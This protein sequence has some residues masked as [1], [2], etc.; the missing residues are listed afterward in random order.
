MIRTLLFIF[1]TLVLVSGT[2]AQTI[3]SSGGGTGAWNDPLS[4]SP[5][6]VPTVA[7]SSSVLIANGHIINITANLTIDQVTVQSGG[8]LIVDPAIVLTLAN[9]TGNEITVDSGGGL[10]NN[11][12]IAFGAIPNRTV[13]VNGDLNNN[14]TF[15][16]VSS[17]KL[18]FNSGANY[19]HQ[20]ADAG[21]I[22]SASWNANSTVNIVGYSSGNS[23]P[24]S[25][26]SQAF[27]HFVWNCP[28]QDLTI[29]L[30]GLPS[31]ING[32]LRIV[33][34]GVDALFYSLGGTGTTLNI[35]G[36]FDVSGG[37]IGFASSDAGPSTWNVAGNFV[38]SGGYVQMADDQNLTVNLTGNFILSGGGQI[39][40]S[41]TS[42]TADINVQGNYTHSGGDLFVNGGIGNVNF[43]GASTKIYT[44]TLVPLGNVNYSVASLSTLTLSGSNFI[45]GGGNFTLNGTL[46][47]GSTAAGGALQTG[48]SNGNL[49]VSGTRTFASNSTIIYN[50]S[51]AQF[52]GNGFPSG[53]DVNLTIDNSSGVTLST[54]LDIVALRTL[55]LASGNIS[56]GA[57]TLTINGTVTGAGGIVGGPTSNLVIGGTGNFGTLA[58]SGTN[59]LQN[60]TLNRTGGAGLIT[61]GGNLTILGTFTHT[62]GVLAVGANTLTITG[63]YGPAAPDDLST[64]AA[65]T[66]I[67]DGAGT[68][69]SDIGLTGGALGTLTLARASVSFITTSTTTITNLNLNSGT[70]NNGTGISIASGGTVT[71][72]GGTISSNLANIL[73]PYNVVYTNGTVTTGPEL[74]SNTTA[75]ANLSKTGSGTLSLGSNIT[76]NGILT[77]SSGSFNSGSNSIDL[78]GNFISS[79]SST[80][81]SSAITFSGTTTISGSAVPTFG[82]ITISG[83]L[84]PSSNF[85]INGNLVNNGTLNAGTATTTFGGTTAISGSST[86]SFNNVVITGILT[87]PVGN[88]NVSGTWTNNGTFNRGIATNTVTFNG[89]SSIGG[90]NPTTFSGITVSGVLNA[91]ATLTLAGNFTN[92]GTFNHSSGTVVFAGTSI[93]NIQG[94]AVT[95]FNNISVTNSTGG[96]PEVQVQSN[97]NLRGV[98]TLAANS[99]FDAD[100]SGNSSVFTL[101]SSADDPASDAAIAALPSGASVTGNVTV[102]RFM[103]IEGANSGR[104]YRYISSPVQ[105]PAVSQ[106]QSEIPITGSFTGSSACTGCGSNQSMFLYDESV[107]T[108]TNGDSFSDFNDGYVDFPNAANSETLTNGR[109]YTLFVRANVAPISSAGSAR[110]DVR[111]PINSGTISFNSFVSFTSSGTLANDGWNL[112]G[113]PYPSTIDWDAAGWTKTGITDAIY[114]RDNGEVS[115]IYA[116][117][118]GGVGANGGTQYIATGQAFFVKSNGGPIDF[119]ATESVKAAGTQT[120]FFREAGPNDLIRIALKKD[121]ITDETVIRFKEDATN[122]FDSNWDAYKLKNA[123][124]NLA[125]IS[126]ET[127]YAINSLSKLSCSSTV[128]LDVS[129]ATVG[130]YNLHFSEFESFDETVEIQLADQFLGLIVNVRTQ[131]DYPFDVTSEKNSHGARF[132]LIFSLASVDNTIVPEGPAELC[133]SASYSITLPASEAGV[134]YYASLNGTTI[135]DNVVGTGNSLEIGIDETKLPL[136]ENNILVYANRS[137]CDAVPMME[138]VVVTRDNIYQVQS[139]VGGTS[140]QEG[141]VTLSA[142]GA[143]ENGSYNWYESLTAT[144]PIS[145]VSGNTYTTPVLDKTKAY[146]VSAVNELGCEGER[147]EVKAEVVKYDEIVITETEYGILTSSYTTGNIWYFNDKVIPGATSQT[148]TVSES[149]TYKAEVTIGACKS[150]S[151]RQ[152][153]VTGLEEVLS[154]I[155]IYPNPVEN[156]VL[157][158]GLENTTTIKLVS[159]IGQQLQNVLVNGRSS[160]T[161]D[162]RDYPSGIYL[163]KLVDKNN[164]ISTHKI[165]KR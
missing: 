128:S 97:Q 56:I 119:Q 108:D 18:T 24:P 78:K 111:A 148:I 70:F 60:F 57:Q 99:Q 65:S 127:K 35:G 19:Y 153:V 15:T 61:L 48:T 130:A 7:N 96:P 98:L 38:V 93:Q 26:L 75:L 31:T 158:R 147:M 94:S 112:V 67:I 63:A 66:I 9:G 149:G 84:T 138:S 8:T 82:S 85:Q 41:A 151:E 55:N 12:T 53:S 143:P 150:S 152:F 161:L 17:S 58:F 103:A 52:I 109:G 2:F 46:Q 125:S 4:W 132:K 160:V 124:F 87:A 145:G 69:P 107:I 28:N 134:T 43:T 90:T 101:V 76:I 102:Q 105:T 44:S 81:T 114:M 79:A 77:L 140:C 1:T 37:V 89:I 32:D 20:F 54:S 16:G 30:G 133:G 86:S 10:T 139:T 131:T 88:F 49:R 33:D 83:T 14:G 146:Y 27:G 162:M 80:L 122:D 23:T 59:Q 164:S 142:S 155:S 50:G 47:V 141:S 156:E 159:N 74:P 106:I 51:A 95:D 22:P 137:S 117:Y 25:G 71:R 6:T 116:S 123:V 13:V 100:G 68:L 154:G 72:S 11:G 121:G 39:D 118:V 5:N 45:G 62:A 104:I 92:N 91:P 165:L 126:G 36:D 3:T 42:G 40:L 136:G 64:T 135:S 29:S 34:T 129:D 120:I 73:D 144:E 163:V 110:W 115:P 21:T 157:I 113:N